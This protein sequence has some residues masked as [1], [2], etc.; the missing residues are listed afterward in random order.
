MFSERIHKLNSRLVETMKKAYHDGQEDEA[1][2]PMVRVDVGGNPLGR[3]KNGDYVIFYNIR[4]E[5]EVYLTQSFT[6]K[7]FDYF[8]RKKSLSLN[9][10]TMIEYDPRVDV[11]V[12]FPSEK[13]I[14]NTLAE[15][16]SNAGLH[17]VKISE[18]EKAIHVGFFMNGKNEEV[19]SQEE[20]V[21]VPSPPE[22]SSYAG[23]PEMSVKEVTREIFSKLRDPSCQAIIANL[24]NVDVIGHIEKKPAVLKA[25]E[26]VDFHLGEII[27]ECQAQR[28]TLVVTSD[29]GTVEEWLYDDGTINT[30]H[31]R[32]PVP[33]ILADFSPEMQEPESL[34]LKEKG[35]LADVAPTVLGL[36]GID[37][38]DE[39]TGESLLETLP[40]QKKKS[41]K[42]LLLILDGWG[43]REES[44]GNLIAEAKTPNFDDLWKRY[45]HSLLKASGEAVGMPSH[46]VGNSEAGHLHLGTGRRVVLDRVKIDNAI[47]D[48]S[49]F[50][51]EAFRWAMQEA[52]RN[53]KSLHLLGIV[54]HYSSHG[55][56][57]HLFALLRMAKNMGLK[58]VYV[59]SLIGRRG[60]KP[61]SGA[62]YV[63]KVEQMCK[64]LLVGR[65]VTVMGRFWALDREENWDRVEKAYR[66][67]VYGE[68]IRVYS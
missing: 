54:S 7:D 24:A 64:E 42:L 4:G 61:E 56:I 47:Q 44:K 29:H 55:T 2:E 46:T 63:E 32:N 11:K 6:D 51:N 33:F 19:F 35:E 66:A 18:S 26:A 53:N 8:P 36:L 65:V 3:L 50:T 28:A 22:V 37:K 38:P 59:H 1:L 20:R 9:F 60:E 25:V 23:N 12:A 68:G 34:V 27:K 41:E 5:R 57:R 16:V 10:I 17:L 45:P 43:M 21:V 40:D 67:L 31:T 30:G 52:K 62:L 39:M 15:A 14:K 13:K 48:G 58:E 49:F